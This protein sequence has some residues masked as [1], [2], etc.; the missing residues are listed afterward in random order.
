MA[1]AKTTKK[2][3]DKWASI[4]PE[5]R[6]TDERRRFGDIQV[7]EFKENGEGRVKGV[8]PLDRACVPILAAANAKNPKISARQKDAALKYEGLRAK[9]DEFSAGRRDSLDMSPRGHTGN[10]DPSGAFLDAKADYARIC[11]GILTQDVHRVVR[12]VVIAHEAIGD[13]R[14]SYRR[15]R[16]LCE[17]LDAL[18]DYWKIP[19]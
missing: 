4:P 19:G 8:V 16:Y 11:A 15:Y 14:P 13:M 12:S 5:N 3:A 6:P 1:R 18:A 2:P 17:G 9:I 10:A 7:V